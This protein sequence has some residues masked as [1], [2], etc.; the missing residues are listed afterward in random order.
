MN[1]FRWTSPSIPQWNGKDSM[2]LQI[3]LLSYIFTRLRI[4]KLSAFPTSSGSLKYLDLTTISDSKEDQK[5]GLNTFLEL[6][7]N[8]EYRVLVDF[9]KNK[10]RAFCIL[11]DDLGGDNN[12]ITY[13]VDQKNRPMKDFRFI[14]LTTRDTTVEQIASTLASSDIYCEHRV[15]MKARYQHALNLI[16]A[17][18]A[19][20]ATGNMITVTTQE[21]TAIIRLYLETMA[22]NVQLN[23]IYDET[24][25]KQLISTPVTIP[26]SS[27][28]PTSPRKPVSNNDSSST[29]RPTLKS[30]PSI[31][32][33]QLDTLYKP[34]L[35]TPTSPV[36]ASAYLI[37]SPSRAKSPTRLDTSSSSA[38]NKDIRIY[39]KCRQAVQARIDSERLKVGSRDA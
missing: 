37:H 39:E 19:K 7:L 2:D 4:N 28:P 35:P 32:R 5:Y 26:S 22:F 9:I 20:Q 6:L 21:A 14:Y 13:L 12:T 10:F 8:D 24:I 33:F 16:V 17:I 30:K 18:I 27:T 36:K 15:P 34:Q 38:E 31:P 11:L 23:R 3:K 25:K 1:I 29:K